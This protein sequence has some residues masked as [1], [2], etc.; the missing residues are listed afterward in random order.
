MDE[1]MLIRYSMALQKCIKS[2]SGE[3]TVEALKLLENPTTLEKIEE[4]LKTDPTEEEFLKK[5]R[6]MREEMLLKRLDVLQK[7]VRNYSQDTTMEL[8][9][10]MDSYQKIEQAE[11]ILKTNP[12]EEEFLRQ[13][14]ELN[15]ISE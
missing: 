4:I 14:R 15:V 13:I 9:D 1:N 6:D 12:T 5:V 3:T 7:C 8:E 11:E 10:A 2:Y